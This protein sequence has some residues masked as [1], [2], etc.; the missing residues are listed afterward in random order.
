MSFSFQPSRFALLFRK[1]LKEE[2]R[3]YF[4]Q[5]AGIWGMMMVFYGIALLSDLHY[6]F[7]N[8]TQE[9]VFVL[10]F[11]LVGAFFSSSF[12]HFFSNKAKAIQFLQLPASVPEK[13]FVGFIITQI[14]FVLA[15]LAMF[16]CTDWIMCNW[17]NAYHKMPEHIRPGTVHLYTGKLFELGSNMGKTTVTAF[18]ILSAI[19]HYGSISFE[20]NAF[21]KTLIITIAVAAILYWGNFYFMKGLIPEESMPGGK[22]YNNTIR[23]G[24]MTNIKGI[25]ELPASWNNF[26]PYFLPLVLYISFWLGSYHKLKEKQ[27]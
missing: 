7:P 2:S 23:I 17:Y 18:F 26:L 3:R 24:P 8:D 1:H 14:M 25:V 27:V 20:K 6:R 13:L 22:F 9:T 15:F 19:T 12:Y 10:G 11:I 4:L 16:Y 5:L 21:P